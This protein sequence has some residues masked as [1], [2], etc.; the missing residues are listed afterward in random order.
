MYSSSHPTAIRVLFSLG[1][2]NKQ[3]LNCDIALIQLNEVYEWR[4]L[5][6]GEFHEDTVD[7]YYHLANTCYKAREYE[8]ALNCLQNANIMVDKL[9][10]K[11]IECYDDTFSEDMW[12]K[13]IYMQM[14]E[15]CLFLGRHQ[16]AYDYQKKV[17]M[18][19][20]MEDPFEETE[21]ERKAGIKLKEIREL[22][23]AKSTK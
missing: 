9:I 14:V 10:D 6:L 3:A 16:E 15:C 17:C 23:S 2:V 12:K 7:A 4:K 13:D 11:K 21:E 22:I 1:K 20:N 5:Y 8:K 18:Y 19:A